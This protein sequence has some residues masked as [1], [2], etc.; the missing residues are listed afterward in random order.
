MIF[1]NVDNVKKILGISKTT[2]YKIIHDLNNELKAQGYIT[3]AGRIPKPFFESR[4][5]QQKDD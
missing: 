4:F 2:A 3:V 1:Y 5:Y